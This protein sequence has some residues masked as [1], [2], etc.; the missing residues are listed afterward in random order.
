MKIRIA[1]LPIEWQDDRADFV[2]AFADGG[3]EPPVM[4]LSFSDKLP[5]CYGIQYADMPLQHL[6]RRADGELLFAD[7]GWSRAVSCFAPKTGGEYA[8][9]LA[10]ICSRFSFYGAL[11]LHAS[12]V[13]S[14]GSGVLFTGCSGVGK[15]TQAEL[16]QQYLGA[17]IVNGDKVAVRCVD[18]GVYA[19]GLPWKGSSEY[20]VNRRAE[21]RC[22]AVL[23]QAK[24]NRVKKLNTAEAA[25]F[26]LPHI[27]LPH[28]DKSCMEN[29]LDTFENILRDVPV[30][31]LECRP[32]E[33]AVR[34]LHSAVLK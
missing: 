27:F 3:C 19:Y 32:D 11:L 7:S 15:T 33:E 17:E 16:W 2:K 21:L 4:S 14:Q 22:I 12:F 28:W 20:C 6:L 10:A 5:E 34:L 31:L 1:D 30:V 8:L 9:P 23:R 29:A 24:E 26:F 18:G 25:K 13:V